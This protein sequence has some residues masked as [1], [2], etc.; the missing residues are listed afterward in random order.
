MLSDIHKACENNVH[1]QNI[2]VYVNGGRQ[3]SNPSFT[4]DVFQ[5]LKK[6]LYLYLSDLYLVRIEECGMIYLL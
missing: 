5:S 4:L 6:H 3:K 1:T 2:A